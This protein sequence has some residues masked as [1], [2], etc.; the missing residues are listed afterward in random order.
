MSKRPKIDHIELFRGLAILAVLLIHV[1]SYPI[2]LLPMHSTLYPLYH[3]VNTFSH[4]AVPAFIFLSALGMFYQY[5]DTRKPNWYS[6]Y[7][8][9]F[10]VIIIPYVLWSFF[11]YALVF[12]FSRKSLTEGSLSYFKG[13]LIGSN[14]AH[15][16]FIIIIVQFYLLFP[17]IH[18]LLLTKPLRSHIIAFGI[19]AQA[20][21]YLANYNYLHL[22]KIGSIAASYLLYYCLGAFVGL[23]MQSN[24]GTFHSGKWI[25]PTWLLFAVMY[26]SQMW[27]IRANPH[28]VPR[29]WLSGINFVTDYSFSAISCLFLLQLSQYLLNWRWHSVTK[30]LLSIG[31]TSLGIYYV[32][33]FLLLVWRAKF[34]STQPILYHPLTWLGGILALALSWVF[35]LILQRRKWGFL[36]VGKVVANKSNT[37]NLVIDQAHQS[38]APSVSSGIEA[39][40]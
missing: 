20:I 2:I 31:A 35:T 18:R 6:F 22:S 14:Y 28:W 4:F 19:A 25:Y 10:K 21:F 26:A 5:D 30:L 17:L 24:N 13:L 33:P 37:D 9:R 29:V 39:K 27:M 34:M 15:L 23:R 32:H 7:F 38:Q 3:I 12:Y 8:K 11:Y 36:I 40:L 1:T 16:Y